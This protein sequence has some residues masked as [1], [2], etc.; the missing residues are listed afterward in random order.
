MSSDLAVKVENLSKC[1]QIYD[2]P[3]DRLL[4][5]LAR[6]HKRYFREFWALKDVS[7][8]VK[9]GETVGIVGRNGS[10]KSTLL[11]LICGTLNPTGGSIQINGRI[12]ALLELGSGF[13]AEFTGRENV[14]I[15]GVVLG[16]SRA[17]VDARYDD[18]AA[19][20]DI[21]EFIDQPVKTYSTGMVVRLAFAVIAHVDADLLVID[22]ALAVGD[23]IFVQKCMRFLRR[24]MQTGTV[25]F[26]SHDIGAIQAL[27]DRAVWLSNGRTMANSDAK[28]VM[29]RYLK[30]IYEQQQG[31]ELALESGI[32]KKP[33]QV[34]GRAVFERGNMRSRFTNATSRQNDIEIF[35]FDE[36]ASGFGL[37]DVSILDVT[38]IDPLGKPLTRVVGGEMVTLQIRLISSRPI[39]N[40]VV[41]FVFKDRLGQSLFSEN[42]FLYFGSEPYVLE[43]NEPMT[44][45]FSFQMPTLP[46]GEYTIDVAVAEGTQTEHVQQLWVHDILTL[47][48]V[49]S[50]LSKGLVGIP[51]D[52][53]ELFTDRFHMRASEAAH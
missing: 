9:K 48:S 50:S 28:S 44:I 18:I 52:E 24:F 1:Y 49:S 39:A 29:D 15:N 23:T 8:E 40:P 21:G 5:M 42:T 10:G 53:V 20:A 26:A 35:E 16:L 37:G 47:V 7:F 43:A 13:N 4:Q 27:C 3:H 38:I 22:E 41:G 2:K 33:P 31:Q 25:L 19:F 30:Y 12:A 34:D 11:Q 32:A 14:Y 17:E 36:D 45:R 6:S 51:I 46:K